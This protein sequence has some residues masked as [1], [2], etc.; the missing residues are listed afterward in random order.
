MCW[1]NEGLEISEVLQ[2]ARSIFEF[3]RRVWAL[4][5]VVDKVAEPVWLEAGKQSNARA[6]STSPFQGLVRIWL[7]SAALAASTATLT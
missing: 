1:A 3:W 5:E 4:V 2:V 7:G 6:F